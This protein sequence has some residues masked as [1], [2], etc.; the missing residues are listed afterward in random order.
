MAQI[1]SQ[2][3]D[4]PSS[5]TTVSTT[6]KTAEQ[7]YNLTALSLFGASLLASFIALVAWVSIGYILIR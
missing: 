1:A 4:V 7:E 3:Q 2:A 6:H 5:R